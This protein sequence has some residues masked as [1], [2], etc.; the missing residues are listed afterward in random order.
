MST[1]KIRIL[2]SGP[3][4]GIPNLNCRLSNNNCKICKTIKRT[5]VS[6]LITKINNDKEESILIDCGK[7]F[8]EQFNS[9]LDEINVNKRLKEK[10]ECDEDLIYSKEEKKLI[11]VS[12]F[13]NENEKFSDSFGSD[14]NKEEKMENNKKRTERKI[15]KLIKK[16]K[17]QKLKE[18]QELNQG[19]G[20]QEILTENFVT[21]YSEINLTKSNNINISIPTLILTHPHADAIG[22]IDTYLMMTN[23]GLSLYCDENTYKILSTVGP[24]YFQ[25]TETRGYFHEEKIN[26]LK[27]KYSFQINQFKLR[28]Y[29]MN[30]GPSKSMAYLIEEKILYI[31][32]CSEILDFQIKTFSNY[33]LEY[34]IID[35]LTINEQKVGH[36]NLENVI[37]YVQQIKPKNTIL[38]GLSH[39]IPNVRK[40]NDFLVAYDGMEF[41]I[42]I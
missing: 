12:T 11:S 35:C 3:S 27:D 17:Y 5:N 24:Y 14:E 41:Y 15:R 6:I 21:D 38:I 40:I 33:S 16:K 34:L 32:D 7:H 31:S 18:F 19:S 20:N 28:S 2:G 25:H 29:S 23:K 8:Y 4:S 39:D 13:I 42:E 37:D 36:L 10:S 1:L 30:H 26:I 22:G 9:Y